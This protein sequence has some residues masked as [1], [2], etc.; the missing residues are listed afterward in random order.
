[1]TPTILTPSTNVW[2]RNLV[3]YLGCQAKRIEEATKCCRQT[4]LWPKRSGGASVIE[5]SG[6]R[7]SRPWLAPRMA[8]NEIADDS[9]QTP[10]LWPL[11]LTLEYPTCQ[12]YFQHC[13]VRAR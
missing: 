4:H 3:H 1:M 13:Q 11:V 2:S 9:C 12:N 6:K 5:D 10:F 8:Y 7:R